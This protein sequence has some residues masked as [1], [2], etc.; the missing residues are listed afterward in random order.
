MHASFLGAFIGL[1]GLVILLAAWRN[2]DWIF[3]FPRPNFSLDWDKA[4]SPYASNL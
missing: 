3:D 1:I 4:E 2:Y